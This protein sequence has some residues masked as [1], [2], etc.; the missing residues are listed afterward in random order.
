MGGASL[1]LSQLLFMRQETSTPIS[2]IAGYA[3]VTLLLAWGMATSI[4][5]LGT[6]GAAEVAQVRV[7]EYEIT[8]AERLRWRGEQT[9]SEGRHYL[10]TGEASLL[11][12]L[13]ETQAGFDEDVRALK[14][15][16]LSPRGAALVEDVVRALTEYRRVLGEL[17][18]QKHS[19]GSNDGLVRRFE[20]ELLPRRLS[21]EIALDRLVTLKEASIKE[22]YAES[23]KH[24]NRLTSRMYATLFVLVLVSLA[25]AFYFSRL[26]GRS[27]RRQQEA[28]ETA[29]KALAAR[30]EILGVVAHDLRNP[31]AAI[32]MAATL[33]RRRAEDEKTR[34]HSES[35][36]T[37]ATRMDRLIGSML[38]VATIDAARFTINPSPSNAE[39]LVEDTISMFENL[40]ATRQIRL[41]RTG[42]VPG[43]WLRAD[44][45][46]L[47]QVFSNLLGNAF[48][49]TPRG[50]VITIRTA[51]AGDAVCFSIAD[52][53]P[54]IVTD[55]IPHLFE[56]FWKKDSPATR[57]T[58]LGLY[59]VKGI[60]DA[61]GGRI[62][63]E[64]SPG[65]GTTFHFTI[66]L[67]KETSRDA[68]IESVVSASQSE[69]SHP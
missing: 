57:G 56:R 55:H 13:R 28:L 21:L 27:F 38:D 32:M 25:I 59:I 60:I 35:I 61:H 1:R 43:L 67:A 2:A 40:S 19:D 68:Q 4:R 23:E 15:D 26:L 42:S 20:N 24:L 62:W 53:G 31:L 11:A 65:R 16:R 10:I 18:A 47:S 50:G 54:G 45:E 17:I 51:L 30:D 52:T 44:P 37:I 14:T 34:K 69:P 5:S 3:I 22:F 48:K 39:R 29:R 41:E 64:S 12:K 46:R 58:G 49:F 7:E 63:V 8:L 6:V 66:P 33:I 9:V 36:E